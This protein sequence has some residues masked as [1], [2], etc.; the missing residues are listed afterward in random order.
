MVL[1]APAIAPRL[2]RIL[3]KGTEKFS[4]EPE[5]TAVRW[6]SWGQSH[7]QPKDGACSPALC[8]VCV[9]L[10]LNSKGLHED[11]GGFVPCSCQDSYVKAERA[12]ETPPH[13]RVGL[14][15]NINDPSGLG[16]SHW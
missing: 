10:H 6:Q 3:P 7:G 4:N 5:D 2:Q 1:D 9:L 13:H 8:C 16:L 15:R 12:R 11:R 14:G